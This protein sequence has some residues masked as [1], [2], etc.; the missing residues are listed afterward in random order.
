MPRRPNSVSKP[1]RVHHWPSLWA[2]DAMQRLYRDMPDVVDAPLPPDPEHAAYLDQRQRQALDQYIGVYPL[3][4]NVG[5]TIPYWA[6]WHPI[7]A[8]VVDGEVWLRM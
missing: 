4:R 5:G 2:L 3:L 8:C 1:K 6:Q 7:A